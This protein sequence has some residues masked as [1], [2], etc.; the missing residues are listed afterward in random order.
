MLMRH[1]SIPYTDRII[2]LADWP[3][4][5]TAMP[6]KML[7]VL[8]LEDGTLLPETADIAMHIA[9]MHD[10]TVPPSRWL[11]PSEPNA[12]HA[13]WRETSLTAAPYL[14]LTDL[15][16]DS[17]PSDA[18]IGA[19]NPLLNFITAEEA[20]PLIPR[21]L[22][23]ATP[24]VQALE[25]RLDDSGPFLGGITPHY[26]D[27]NT[28]HIAD[29]ITTIDGGRALESCSLSVRMWYASVAALPAVADYLN[30]RPQPG[31]GQLGKPGSLI[32]EFARPHV[33][34]ASRAK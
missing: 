10:L 22:A 31:T 27:F 8:E 32:H 19:C 23:Y 29:Q 11:L 12:A 6:N 16:A 17:M 14:N 34:I 18:R 5:K 2:Q 7:P 33:E 20:L 13:C 24:W 26:G 9:S 3:S 25:T 1:A 15:M 30:M 4:L 28:F 21:Y